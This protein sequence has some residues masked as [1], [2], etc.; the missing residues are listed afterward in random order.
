MRGELAGAVIKD[1]DAGMPKPE[2]EA[3][4][5]KPLHLVVGHCVDESGS[6]REK[7]RF[8][9]VTA[10]RAYDLLRAEIESVCDENEDVHVLASA[11]PGADILAL[12]I[13]G[14]LGFGCTMCLPMPPDVFASKVFGNLHEWH[15]RF[16]DLRDADT[17]VLQLSDREGVSRWLRQVGIDPWDRGNRWVMKLAETWGA[18]RVSLI[19]LWDEDEAAGTTGGT[20]Q[21]VALAKA[22]G[23]IRIHVVNSKELLQTTD[24][25]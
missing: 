18:K 10:E 3:A 2:E 23:N 8:P 9:D 14:E 21:M 24:V 11:A 17:P 22:A 5:A 6:E 1:I 13:C 7:A 20:A 25:R 19:A 15:R 16:M 12:E 4:E